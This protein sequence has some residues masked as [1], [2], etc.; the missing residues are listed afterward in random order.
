MITFS[1]LTRTVILFFAITS[2]SACSI[3]KSKEDEELLPVELTK[4]QQTEK[5]KRIW[6]TK[7]GGSSD[8]FLLGLSPIG[9]GNLIY[10]ASSDGIVL[11]IDPETGDERWKVDLEVD[12]SAG[13]GVGE[14]F[15]VVIS[16]DG[17]VILLN[18]SSGQEQWRKSIE[19]ESLAKPL[20]DDN[21]III[22]T[23]DNRIVSL[24]RADG[25][26]RW[27]LEQTMPLLS[28]RGSASP[29]IV[30]PLIIAGFD[31][32]RLAGIDMET[33]D[34]KWDSMLSMSSG[35][36]DLDRLS[37]I[38]GNIAVVGQDIYA[39]G[40]QGRL[41]AFAAESGQTLWSRE[42]S[43]YVGVA[44][45]WNSIYTIRDDGEIIALRRNSGIE[46][47][48]ND[49]LLRRA[50]TLPT[51]FNTAV[52]VGDYQGYLHF[53][54]AING[55]QIARIRFGRDAITSKPLVMG[56]RL[57]IQSDNGNIGAFEIVKN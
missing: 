55:K 11:A 27:E 28:M 2:L 21:M 4:F 7:I 13:P 31:N 24:A 39:A 29:L 5:I 45:D 42:I 9:D 3:F 17:D 26:Q 46:I 49:E 12:L 57:F 53:L 43:S 16:K 41:S 33:G 23:I 25:R 35:R 6:S 37:D 52:V 20:I 8:Q 15:T 47:W 50:L 32:G 40:Y 44:S 14:G 30:G 38:D 10:A 1:Q 36:S 51:P 19:G 34:I 18:S 22:Q 48:R 54:S 56:N